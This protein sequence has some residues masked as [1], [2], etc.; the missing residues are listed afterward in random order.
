MKKIVGLAVV[1]AS[2][3]LLAGC[4]TDKEQKRVSSI[5]E[6]SSEEK[7]NLKLLVSKH[8]KQMN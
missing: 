8:S 2:I 4:N 5:S 6:S 3:F 7:R 1:T